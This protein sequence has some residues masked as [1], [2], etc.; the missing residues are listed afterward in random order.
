MKAHLPARLV[1]DSYQKESLRTPRCMYLYIVL[2]N[3]LALIACIALLN[4]NS[5]KI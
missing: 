2:T 5:F 4:I 3:D 1:L